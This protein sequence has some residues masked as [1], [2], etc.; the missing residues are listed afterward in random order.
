MPPIKN[1]IVKSEMKGKQ[2]FSEFLTAFS[3]D[4]AIQALSCVVNGLFEGAFGLSN[5]TET[6]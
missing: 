4:E 1:C 2:A 5:S 3:S 6:Q